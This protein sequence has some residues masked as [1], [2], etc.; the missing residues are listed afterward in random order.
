MS[1]EFLT[2]RW[3]TTSPDT[4]ITLRIPDSTCAGLWFEE[5]PLFSFLKVAAEAFHRS[6]SLSESVMW[7]NQLKRAILVLFSGNAPKSKEESW[8]FEEFLDDD[9]DCIPVRFDLT[10]F[11]GAISSN[12]QDFGT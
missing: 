12:E 4:S 11:L 10:T 6:K 1:V 9:E 8:D 3:R 2:L 5:L 7:F